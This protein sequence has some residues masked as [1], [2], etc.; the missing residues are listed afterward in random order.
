MKIFGAEI[1]V[2]RNA[3]QNNGGRVLKIDYYQPK[4]VQLTFSN[5]DILYALK[6]ITDRL[7]NA[8]FSFEKL[9]NLSPTTN[10]IKGWLQANR[11]Q[12]INRLFYDG[13]FV[14]S[15]DPNANEYLF[16]DNIYN[17][18][19]KEQG[20]AKV[21][22]RE[23]EVIIT[24]ETFEST[25][26][27]DA[28]FL[29]DKLR[30]FDAINSSDFNLIENY[31]AMGIVSPEADNSVAGAEFTEQDI[32]ELQDKYQKHYG[33]T[34]G[35]WSLMFVPRPTKYTP[36][37]LPISQLQLS[38]KRLYCLKALFEAL[39]I[40]KELSTY[41]DN[42]TFENRKQAELDFYSNAVSAWARVLVKVGMSIYENIRKRTD[43]LVPN[44]LYYDFKGVLVLQEEQLKEKQA[45]REELAFWQTIRTTEPSQRE[46]ADKRI[47]DL[48]ENL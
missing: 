13:Y 14:L 17:R 7:S 29:R 6:K 4:R 37:Q 34:L 43:Y 21:M 2:I 47:D 24:S 31:G 40:P 3:R 19:I 11:L 32:A 45:A 12:I 41:F 30:F 26:H 1:K 36:I 10:S 16:V 27:S 33:I 23:C 39:N 9:D 22:L 48:L 35:K 18:V 44:E 5:G 46:L 28:Y 25:G 42:S 8:V 38:E 20:I 15:I